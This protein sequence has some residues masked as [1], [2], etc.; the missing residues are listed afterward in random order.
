MRGLKGHKGEKVK[1]FK[2]LAKKTSKKVVWTYL[3]IS[4]CIPI[5][6]FQHRF[7]YPSARE[8]TASPASREIWVSKATG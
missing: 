7:L 8:K 5:K 3:I 2:L 1:E 4:A 6:W